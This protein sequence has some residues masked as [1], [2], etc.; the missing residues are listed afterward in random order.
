MMPLQEQ[1]VARP[2]CDSMN[3]YVS[4]A[5]ARTQSDAHGGAA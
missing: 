2:L 1:A 5:L 3:A 4:R